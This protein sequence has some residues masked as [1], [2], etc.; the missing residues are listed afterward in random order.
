VPISYAH[1][2]HISNLGKKFVREIEEF[3]VNYH[4][5]SGKQYRILDVRGPSKA[6]SRLKDGIRAAKKG[7][8]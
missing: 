3:F 2:K 1:V 7:R 4:E 8:S 5:L 6:R